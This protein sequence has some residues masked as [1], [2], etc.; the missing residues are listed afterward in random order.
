VP[1]VPLLYFISTVNRYKIPIKRYTQC[2]FVCLR[3]FCNK[4]SRIATLIYYTLRLQRNTSQ[5]E[6]YVWL[7][8]DT[9]DLSIQWHAW[10]WNTGDALVMGG[11]FWTLY[12]VWRAVCMFMCIEVRIIFAEILLLYCFISW[13]TFTIPTQA[14]CISILYSLLIY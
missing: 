14:M 12:R 9:N 10:T 5:F 3:V 2:L 1:D 4:R 13:L 11:L 8:C 7:P 6:T